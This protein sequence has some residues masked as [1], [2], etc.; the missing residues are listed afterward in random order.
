[1]FKFSNQIFAPL[2][3]WP[4]L[5]ILVAIWAKSSGNTGFDYS[6]AVKSKQ[7]QLSKYLARK[8]ERPYL[9]TF[10]GQRINF[11]LTLE[12]TLPLSNLLSEVIFFLGT[13]ILLA[14]QW[15]LHAFL[16]FH[17]HMNVC[18]IRVIL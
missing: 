3:L 18:L 14:Q 16:F 6:S 8:F 5:E 15:P 17:L 1:M 10:F 2:L 7:Q 4:Y 11:T 12:K 9:F 13:L